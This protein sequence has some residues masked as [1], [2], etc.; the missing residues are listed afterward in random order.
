MVKEGCGEN[1]FAGY[2]IHR[3][4]AHR[5]KYIPGTHL[6]SIIIAAQSTGSLAVFFFKDIADKFLGF[7]WGGRVIV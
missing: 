5:C 6:A 3:V 4:K 1:I 7:K 2:G